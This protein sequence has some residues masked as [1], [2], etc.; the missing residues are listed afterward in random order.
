MLAALDS[1]GA[2][3]LADTEVTA[4]RE[5]YGP[6]AIAA[7]PSPSMW[8]IALLQLRDPMNLMLVAVAVVSVLIDQIP[9]GIMVAALVVL[10]V[11]LGTRQEL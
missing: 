4:R 7:Q 8:A 5:R 2:A 6:N 11:V 10:N 1:D 9:V 3:G